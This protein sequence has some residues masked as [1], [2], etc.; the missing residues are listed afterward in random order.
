MRL[1]RIDDVVAVIDPVRDQL[2]DQA[3]RMLAVAVHEQHRAAPGMVQPRH[4]RGFLAEIARQRHHLDV[5]RVGGKRARDRKRGV[6]AAVVD[7]DH[8]AGEAVALPAASWRGRPAARAASASPAA[9]LY[10]GTTIDSPCAAALAAVVDR[11]ETSE[12]SVID[13]VPD[14]PTSICYLSLACRNDE[15]NGSLI[16]AG[17]PQAW[18]TAGFPG[19]AHSRARRPTPCRRRARAGKLPSA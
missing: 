10:R 3:R 7:I 11:R 13:Q 6:G 9:S 14:H 4:Q 2:F 15:R 5:E 17:T 16:A 19:R 8:F 18:Q 12:P 1:R